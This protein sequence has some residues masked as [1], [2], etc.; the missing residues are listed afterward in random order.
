[1]AQKVAITPKA[2]AEI[3]DAVKRSGAEVVD[4]GSAE[5]LVWFGGKPAELREVLD[6]SSGIR[7]VQLP[8]AGIENMVEVLDHDRAA[9]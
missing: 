1:M 8:F 7:W 6:R 9:E 2:P 4:P 3:L 5:V